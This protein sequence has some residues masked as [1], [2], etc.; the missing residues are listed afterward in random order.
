[1]SNI[2]KQLRNLD[3]SKLKMKNGRTV[4]Q[5]L[6]YHARIL[7]DCIM[8]EMNTVYESYS[9]KIYR[10]SYDV[11]NSLYIDDKVRIDVSS[12]G[13]GLSIGIHFNDGSLHENFYG[14]D[15]NIIG[16][17]NEGW[18][19]KNNPHI[20]Y[21]SERSGSHFIEKGI[22]KYKQKVSKPFT[23]K[24]TINGEERIF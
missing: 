4:E 20:P 16:L 3:V 8:E 17:W 23:V 21:L 5:E 7:S 24:F 9:P 19:W 18:E 14:N 12:K 13:T 22:E 2:K 11:Y 10:R 6:R 1:M 15:S